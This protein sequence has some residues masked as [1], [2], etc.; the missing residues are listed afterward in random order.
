MLDVHAPNQ[1]VHTWK[2]YFIHLA[3]ISIGLLI[4]IGLEQTVEYFHQRHQVREMTE[5]IQEESLE[6]R[7]TLQ[8][9]FEE[10]DRIIA[11]VNTNLLALASR[12]CPWRL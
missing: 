7:K 1:R 3:T 2:N 10:A 11:V 4:A 8:T 6:N 9:E 12:R 5:K